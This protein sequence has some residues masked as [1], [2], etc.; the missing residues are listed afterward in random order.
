MSEISRGLTRVFSDW[1]GMGELCQTL[2]SIDNGVRQ[3]TPEQIHQRAVKVLL[4]ENQ[5]LIAAL[6]LSYEEWRLWMPISSSRVGYWTKSFRG[7][8][9]WGRT[10]LRKWP[11]EEIYIRRKARV[12]DH[13]TASVVAWIYGCLG[14]VENGISPRDLNPTVSGAVA[15]M[16]QVV[17][18]LEGVDTSEPSDA[19]LLSLGALGGI[20]PSVAELAVR[21]KRFERAGAADYAQ[22]LMQP[23]LAD[24]IFQLAVLGEVILG[25]ESSGLKMASLRPITG[26]GGPVYG[27][28]ESE[29][30]VWWEASSIWSTLGIPNL[31]QEVSR[32]AFSSDIAPYLARADRPDILIVGP[33]RRLL[34]L[35]CKFPEISG[36]RGYISGG[37]AQ[38]FFYAKQ[39]ESA[40]G[41]VH[42]YS[43]GP[44]PLV[45]SNVSREV[46]QVTVGLAGLDHVQELV[47]SAMQP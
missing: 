9:D 8:V 39:L 27:T 30:F 17:A 28:L 21:L 36:D 31:R 15:A 32:A 34:V 29:C 5:S 47:R 11:P 3:W 40:F 33:H 45:E 41:E 37:M 46:N 24:R 13:L 25:V 7:R 23:D 10:A 19:E 18:D 1:G 12:V 42:A 14:R 22:R 2:A 35:E 26:G 6:P 16:A 44:S 43:V 38:A 20:W 4:L